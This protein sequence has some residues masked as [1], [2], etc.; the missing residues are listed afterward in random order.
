MKVKGKVLKL[1]FLTPKKVWFKWA[2][3]D[4][5]NFPEDHALRSRNMTK[6][7]FTA[8]FKVHFAGVAT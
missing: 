8:I 7:K 2:I 5:Q 6:F 4:L 1:D 3:L